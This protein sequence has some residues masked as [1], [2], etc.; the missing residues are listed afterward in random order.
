MS[1]DD[2]RATFESSP[3]EALIDAQDFLHSVYINGGRND[4][5]DSVARQLMRESAERGIEYIDS[6]ISEDSR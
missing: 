3:R 6:I 1:A 5:T 2:P 4:L